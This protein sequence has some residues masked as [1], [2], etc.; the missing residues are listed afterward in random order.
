M[1]SPTGEFP[2]PAGMNRDDLLPAAVAAGVP[3]TRGDEPNR[4]DYCRGP[5][6]T[7]LTNPLNLLNPDIERWFTFQMQGRYSHVG[8]NPE[9]WF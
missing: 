2:A 4:V 8:E 5:S 7:L 1:S 9:G 3:R 6:G